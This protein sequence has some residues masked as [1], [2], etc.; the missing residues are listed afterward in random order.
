MR[1][2]HIYP[3]SLIY[4]WC[5]IVIGIHRHIKFPGPILRYIPGSS[6][7]LSTGCLPTRLKDPEPSQ[8]QLGSLPSEAPSRNRES[9]T[10]RW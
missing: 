7:T 9:K 4:V 8:Q 5:P 6:R 1:S 3:L 2:L 10:G